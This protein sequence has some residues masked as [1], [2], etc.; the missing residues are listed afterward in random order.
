MTLNV[1]RHLSVSQING[2]HEHHRVH[3]VIAKCLEKAESRE[4]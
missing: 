1:T 2:Q 4:F 3:E